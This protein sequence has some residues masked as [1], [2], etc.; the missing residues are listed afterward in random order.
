MLKSMTGYGK[1]E[2]ASTTVALTVEIRSVNHRYSDIGV[3]APRSL[4]PLE[5][6]IRKRVGERLRRGKIDVFVTQ[7]SLANAASLPT[8]NRPLA[9]AYMALFEQMRE[10]YALEGGVPLALLATQKDVLILRESEA[11]EE[12]VRGTLFGAL[13][14]AVGALE[15]MR[16][17]E[18]EAIR[19]DM[20][21]RLVVLEELL[22]GIEAR[23]PQVPR[24]WQAKLQERLSRLGR[25]ADCDPQRLAQEIA[26]FADRCD[27]SEELVR[28]RSHLVQ[29]RGLL[30]AP[31]PVG[32]QMD[33]LVQEL[34][35]EANTMGSKSNDADLTRQVVAL[36]AELEKVR[37][38]VQNV[39]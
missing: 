25:D 10:G 11:G 9:D 38:Q 19:A 20:E 37:E 24:E 5:G 32:R 1:G 12:D 36:K 35:R 30:E 39:E 33:F 13:D 15:R 28:F 22:T 18:G 2:A 14:R 4:L 7:E 27:I 16:L 3:K 34:N 31:E 6:E 21:V 8:L 26:I 23:A 29:F 17:A